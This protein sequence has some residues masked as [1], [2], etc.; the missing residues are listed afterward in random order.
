MKITGRF[1]LRLKT[2]LIFIAQRLAYPYL[3]HWARRKDISE[4]KKYLVTSLLVGY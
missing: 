4:Y 1:E 3:D 2:I